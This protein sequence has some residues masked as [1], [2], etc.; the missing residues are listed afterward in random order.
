M[1]RKIMAI[2]ISAWAL[3]SVQL[4]IAQSPAKLS[5]RIGFIQ[6]GSTPVSLVDGFR[7]GLSELGWIEQQN[8]VIEYR[9]AQGKFDQI[10]ALVADLIKLK[11][12]VIF[13]ANIRVALAAKKATSTIPIV[14]LV[15]ADPVEA[16]LVI[17]LAHPGGNVTGLVRFISELSGKRLELFKETF[18]KLSIVAILWTPD[19]PGPSVAFKETQAAAQSLG[20]QLQSFE[21]RGPNDFDK[22]FSAITKNHTN[23]LV[24]LGGAI[25]ILQRARILEFA[26]KSRLPAI[27]D[28][29]E[30]VNEGGLMFY[31]VDEPELFRRAATYVD[32]IL[33]GANPADLPV[34]QP[35][36]FELVINLKTASRST[37]SFHR[38]CWR[39]RIR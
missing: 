24:V 28:R 39:E 8:I 7:K 12:D 10:P 35:K 1:N 9:R 13:T 23:G 33:K 29:P 16:G 2:S 32:K 3:A 18:P 6:G 4:A 20:I 26:A 34:E 31:G 25:T 22:A 14:I 37:S 30:D 15:P 27:Y 19:S 11:V 5:R 21:V 36:K 17:S 38:M